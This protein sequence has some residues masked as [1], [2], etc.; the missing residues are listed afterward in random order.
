LKSAINTLATPLPPNFNSLCSNVVAGVEQDI[1]AT[2]I[3]GVDGLLA[4][5]NLP[6]QVSSFLSNIKFSEDVSYQ[7][8]RFSIQTGETKLQEFIASGKNNG[9]QIILAYMKVETSG[10]PIQQYVATRRCKSSWIVF[11]KCSTVYNPRGFTTDEIMSI[12]N[13][14]LFH[15][16]NKLLNEVDSLN[17]ML[18]IS[19][20]IA[21]PST[22]LLQATTEPEQLNWLEKA[23]ISSYKQLKEQFDTQTQSEV[24]KKITNLGFNTFSEDAEIKYIKNMDGK[25]F[26]AFSQ[27]LVNGLDVDEETRKKVKEYMYMVPFTEIGQWNMMRTMFNVNQVSNANYLCLMTYINED[28]KYS[29]YTV[30][31]K[32]SFEIAPDILIVRDSKSS[33]GGLFK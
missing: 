16:Y 20:E 5:W 8:Y 30:Q 10:S 24:V 13:G 29:I 25:Y 32:N 3:D 7:T 2:T 22:H 18:A 33:W 23:I 6:T 27:N 4:S 11:N 28:N 15:G 9:E 14:L 19:M 12:Q 1:Q 21:E 17:T 26:D 31:M